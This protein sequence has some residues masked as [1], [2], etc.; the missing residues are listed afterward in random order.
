M[1]I[2]IVS[3]YF[4]PQNKIAAVRTTKIAKYLKRIGHEVEIICS[5]VN[6]SYV[7]P[8]LVGDIELIGPNNIY[9]IS[10]HLL[11]RSINRRLVSVQLSPC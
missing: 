6:D 8:I 4:A 3:Y 5:T 9:R 10:D 2:L 11:L 1:K 7:D